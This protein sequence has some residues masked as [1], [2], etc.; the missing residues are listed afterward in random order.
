SRKRARRA[1]G[2]LGLTAAPAPQRTS[3]AKRVS[4]PDRAAPTTHNP[5]AQRALLEQWREQLQPRLGVI[6]LQHALQQRGIQRQQLGQ[7]MADPAGILV[8]RL[9]Q[10]L[11]A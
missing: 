3:P 10:T 1:A 8:V 5:S 9:D 4:P 7:P 6:E 11:R 2:S